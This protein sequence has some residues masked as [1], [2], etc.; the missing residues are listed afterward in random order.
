[1]N[2]LQ[3]IKSSKFG[4]VECDIYSNKKEMFMTTN[5]LS[6]CLGYKEKNGIKK[7]VKRCERPQI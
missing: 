4:E 3:L 7:I 1:M 6:D 2:N 5:Q